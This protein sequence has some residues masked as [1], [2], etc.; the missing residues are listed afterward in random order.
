MFGVA[1]A[2]HNAVSRRIGSVAR[3]G[4]GGMARKSQYNNL[5]AVN[6]E[7]KR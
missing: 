5:L 4:R 7:K 6:H 3:M 1:L 2:I